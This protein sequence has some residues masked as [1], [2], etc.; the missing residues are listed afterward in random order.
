MG[1]TSAVLLASL[2]LLVMV[3]AVQSAATRCKADE[4]YNDCRQKTCARTCDNMNG[5]C[6]K[7]VTGCVCK[8]GTVRN[9][10]G[11]CVNVKDCCSGNTV[12]DKCGN[13]CGKTCEDAAHPN[14]PAMCA[15]VCSSGCFCKPGY[16]LNNS[17]ECV[18][19]RHC[20]KS[21]NTY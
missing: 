11:K 9:A 3:I 15:T 2:T 1:R 20:P 16:V 4:E 21:S 6:D 12:Y 14:S 19:P 5:G 8:K 7:C 10:K 13:N 18:L 17:G